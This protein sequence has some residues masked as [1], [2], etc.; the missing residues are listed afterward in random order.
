MLAPLLVLTAIH[1]PI[2]DLA[3]DQVSNTITLVL[4]TSATRFG[5]V[6]LDVDQKSTTPVGRSSALASHPSHA[7]PPVV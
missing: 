4:Q 5:F 2:V 3:I 7:L 1:R 6:S